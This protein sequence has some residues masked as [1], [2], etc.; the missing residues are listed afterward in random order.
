M[1]GISRKQI[2]PAL[3]GAVI[4]IAV[5]TGA[6]LWWIDRQKFETTDNAFV[7]AD[8]VSIGPQVSGSVTEVLVADNQRVTAGQILVK[9]DDSTIR[10]RLNQAVANAAALDAGIRGVDDRARAHPARLPPPAR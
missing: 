3:G 9:L 5:A 7:A 8:T 6:S 4:L 1:A 2:L 10:A